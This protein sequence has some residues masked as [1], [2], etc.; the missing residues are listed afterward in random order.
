MSTMKSYL[1]WSFKPELQNQSY[2]MKIRLI[3]ISTHLYGS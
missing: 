3:Q 2:T 1:P